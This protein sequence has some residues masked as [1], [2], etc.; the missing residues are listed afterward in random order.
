L[1]CGLAGIRVYPNGLVNKSSRLK[2]V[3]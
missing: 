2:P 3:L 1:S